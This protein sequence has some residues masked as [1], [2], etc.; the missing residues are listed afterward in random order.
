MC[1]LM[2]VTFC[3]KGKETGIVHN[4][5]LLFHLHQITRLLVL[6]LNLPRNGFFHLFVRISVI[7]RSLVYSIFCK[8]CSLVRISL[9]SLRSFAGR[10]LFVCSYGSLSQQRA[11]GLWG[12]LSSLRG[13]GWERVR[14]GRRKGGT[15]LFHQKGF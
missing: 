8:V 2:K 3:S 9:I 10:S 15:S 14:K 5:I 12:E 6:R 1:Y 11:S 4:F 13:E 7:L